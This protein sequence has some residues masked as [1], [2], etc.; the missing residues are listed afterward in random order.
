MLKTQVLLFFLAGAFLGTTTTA[1]LEFSTTA[2]ISGANHEWHDQRRPGGLKSESKG[3][4]FAFV[5]GGAMSTLL[6]SG[7][8]RRAAHS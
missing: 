8:G 4:Q 7:S 5:D 2:R 1:P 6:E 3:R